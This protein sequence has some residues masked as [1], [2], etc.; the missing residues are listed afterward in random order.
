M[1]KEMIASELVK[2]AKDLLGYGYH[3]SYGGDPYWI[4]LRFSG[5]CD[6]CHAVL[7]KGQRAFY[8]PRTRK[9]FGEPCGHGAEADQDFHSMVEQEEGHLI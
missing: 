8:Y 7:P 3:K 9:L 2:I 5:T 4:T 1:N 6:K